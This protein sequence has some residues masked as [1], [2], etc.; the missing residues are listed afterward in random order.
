MLQDEANRVR[1]TVGSLRAQLQ[2]REEEVQSITKKVAEL[3]GE[4]GVAS[5]ENR[6]LNAQIQEHKEEV[7]IRKW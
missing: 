4:L 2:Q 5:A 6:K 7:W 3:E 1:D